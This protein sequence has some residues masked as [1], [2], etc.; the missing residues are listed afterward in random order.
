MNF[1]RIAPHYRWLETITMGHALQRCRT[2]WLDT[3]TDARDDLILGEGNGRFLAEC[4][5][6]LKEARFTVV[7]GSAKMLALAR[8][9]HPDAVFIQAEL[10]GWKP[11]P[12]SFDLIVTHFFLDCFP[13]EEVR[14]VVESLAAA[15][16]PRARWLLADFREPER[17]ARRLRARLLLALAY[18][19]FGIAAGVRAHR[20]TAPDPTLT[21]CGFHLKERVLYKAGLLH[22]DVWQRT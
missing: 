1:D 18:G 19:F 14:E 9:R 21:A 16:R 13:A 6:R 10:P 11:L 2:A 3:V 22:S 8:R 7:D 20:L 17:G 12:E 4:G 15:A 5:C